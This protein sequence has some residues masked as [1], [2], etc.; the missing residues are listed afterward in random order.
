MVDSILKEKEDYLKGVL[1]L[2]TIEEIVEEI[3]ANIQ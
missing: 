2:K 1:K 3:I